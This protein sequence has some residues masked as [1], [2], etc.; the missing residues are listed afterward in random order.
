MIGNYKIRVIYIRDI[1]LATEH[2]S[3]DQN[4]VRAYKIIHAK[5]LLY[6]VHHSDALSPD[7]PDS[8]DVHANIL[9]ALRHMECYHP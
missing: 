2:A 8:S 5:I 9:T 3:H 1:S 7:P 6:M 4:M